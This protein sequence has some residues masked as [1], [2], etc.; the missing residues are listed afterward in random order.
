MAVIVIFGV[1]LLAKE[2]DAIYRVEHAWIVKM[3][4]MAVSVTCRV[5]QT[6]KKTYVTYKKEHVLTVNLVGLELNVKQVRE[7]NRDVYLI[8][9]T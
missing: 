1:Q 5:L 6:V 8:L 3:E 2:A 9:I 7:R 4:Y